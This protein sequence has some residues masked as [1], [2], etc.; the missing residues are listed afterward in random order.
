MKYLLV[1]A[2]VFLVAWRWRSTRTAQLRTR[3]KAA[4]SVPLDMVRCGQCGVHL[5]A[6]DAV[7]GARGV[8]YCS[9]AHRQ[10]VER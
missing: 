1:L 10:A 2:V 7:A 5:P 9:V 4:P 3:T 8:M 6:Q